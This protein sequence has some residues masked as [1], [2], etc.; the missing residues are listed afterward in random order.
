MVGWR[1]L[2][3]S[4]GKTCCRLGSGSEGGYLTPESLLYTARGGAQNE[5]RCWCG[6]LPATWIY[7]LGTPLAPPYFH[8]VIAEVGAAR[9][10]QHKSLYWTH[11]QPHHIWEPGV[12]RWQGVLPMWPPTNSMMGLA[13][14]RQ[15]PCRHICRALWASDPLRGGE[16]RELLEPTRE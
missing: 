14:R 2:G 16:N 15:W 11:H 5:S 3:A 6:S 4:Q 9:C 7:L 12:R 1:R 13:M 10:L 8:K